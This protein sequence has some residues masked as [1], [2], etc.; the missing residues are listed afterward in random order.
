MNGTHFIISHD[1]RYATNLKPLI[2]VYLI[3][4]HHISSYKAHR[5]LE[6][7]GGDSF[8][9][10][11]STLIREELIN[12]CGRKLDSFSLVPYM[13][14]TKSPTLLQTAKETIVELLLD[15]SMGKIPPFQ[16]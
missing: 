5:I 13:G 11:I 1:K 15:L 3:M 4:T 6:G 8:F 14:T 10:W 7:K 2:I 12:C 9:F 16:F